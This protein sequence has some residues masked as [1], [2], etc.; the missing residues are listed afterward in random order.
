MTLDEQKLGKT[1]TQIT[2]ALS[3]GDPGILVN[4]GGNSIHFAVAHLLDE[5]IEIIA[6]RLRALLTA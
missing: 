4:S 5:D 1:A 3:E 2:D 6:E